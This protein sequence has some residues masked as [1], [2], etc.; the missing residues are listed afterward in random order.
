MPLAASGK[1]RCYFFSRQHRPLITNN[2]PGRDVR[3]AAPGKL[4]AL[5]GF[6]LSPRIE[7]CGWFLRIANDNLDQRRCRDV[8]GIVGH[9]QLKSMLPGCEWFVSGDSYLD[10]WRFGFDR[11]ACDKLRHA[12]SIFLVVSSR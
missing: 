6:Y 2:P 11:L 12:S 3:G 4:K 9:Y 5:T 8:A 1:S 7:H 10:Y